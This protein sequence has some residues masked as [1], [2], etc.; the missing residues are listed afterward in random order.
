VRRK[1]REVSKITVLGGGLVGR[2]IARD[3]AREKG[4]RIIVADRDE[5]K[6]ARLRAESLATTTVDLADD[7]AVRKAIADADVVVGA[8]PGHMGYR[9][10]RLVIEAGKPY[11]DIAFMPEDFL[12]LDGLARE[13]GVTAVVDCGVAP[14]LSN[15]LCGRAEH[16]FDSVERMLILVGGLPKNRLWPFEYRVVFS[17]VDVIEEYLRPARWVEHGRLVT[18]PALTDVE[19]V[20]L[21]RVGTVEAFNTDGLRSLATTLHAPFMKEK[22]LRWP[23]HVEKMRMLRETG[24][25]S[26]EPIDVAG[27][28]VRPYDMT[29]K[30]LFDAWRLPE[31]EAD[32]T[33]MRVEATG[34][35]GG[36][37]KTW[38]WDLYDEADPAT[39]Y[40]SMAR[41]TGFPCAIVARML[42]SGELARPGVQPPERLAGD[43]RFF[44]RMMDELRARGVTITRT[45]A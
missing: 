10:L 14:G 8:A 9:L 15:L 13:R 35:V 2:V 43:D 21:P 1:E 30:L 3:L 32:L 25:L 40:H 39:G 34:V 18:K 41:V 28:R 45:I 12:Q 31:G 27:T 6:L 37:P 42:A 38:T 33:V 23:G 26:Q 36:A 24:F 29:T 11:A 17:A 4:F 20:D 19:P 5:G 44:E 16:E 22:T 7:A